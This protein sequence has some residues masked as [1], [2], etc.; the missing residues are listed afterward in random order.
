VRGVEVKLLG[1]DP[2]ATAVAEGHEHGRE[3]ARSPKGETRSVE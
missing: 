2:K 3:A 1:F